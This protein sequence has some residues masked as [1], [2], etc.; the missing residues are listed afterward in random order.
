MP[1][2]VKLPKTLDLAAEFPPVATA[3]W[4]K[5]IVED[6]KGADYAKKLIWKAEGLDIRPYHRKEDLPPALPRHWPATPWE[7]RTEP[8]PVHAINGAK[9]HNAGATAVQ[10][11]GYA[12]AEGIDRLAA[13]GAPASIEFTFAAG[14][15]FLIE[16]AKFRAARAVWDQVLATFDIPAAKRTMRIHAVTSTANKSLLDPDTNL[17]RCTTEAFSA[18]V[19]G[20]DTLFIPAIGVDARLAKNIQ[21]ILKEEAQADK[22]A[23]PAGGSY[24]LEAI[25]DSIAKAAWAIIKE[26]EAAGGYAKAAPAME[27]AIA[28]ARSARDKAVA[29]R[30]QTLVGVNNYPGASAPDGL[31]AKC[32][33]SLGWRLAL[34]L[35]RIRLRTMQ[36]AKRTGAAPRVLMLTR[37]DVAMRVARATFIRNFLG[38]AGFD[39]V[40][41]EQLQPADLVVLCSSDPEYVDLAKDVCPKAGAPVI[42]AGNPKEQIEAL[43]AAGVAGFIHVMSNLVETLTQ[44]QD[45]LGLPALEET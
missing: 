40:E 21:L 36:H 41:S 22:V 20:C 25:T 29:T 14:S 37:G 9:L 42:V 24:T 13:G 34:P 1:D 10:E 32:L 18:V 45:K 2:I 7:I 39:I 30:R 31:T 38:C 33:G 8:P 43:T 28:A 23:D 11:V 44:W 19:G 17:L 4:E 26:V 3:D 35:E 12:I 15:L 5:T 16:I 6:L 27:A